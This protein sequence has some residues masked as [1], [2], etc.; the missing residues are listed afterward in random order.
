MRF[1]HFDIS[2]EYIDDLDSDNPEAFLLV[3]STKLL[4]LNQ[5]NGRQG[6]LQN[7]VGIVQHRLATDV[8]Q[9]R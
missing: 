8:S 2:D 3:H 5:R 6:V 9:V 4:D 7:L 1:L